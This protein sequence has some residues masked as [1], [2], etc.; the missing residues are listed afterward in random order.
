MSPLPTNKET[1]MLN[2]SEQGRK[3]AIEAM[4]S[5]IMEMSYLEE[6]LEHIGSQLFREEEEREYNELCEVKSVLC[7]AR[8][9]RGKLLKYELQYCMYDLGEAAVVTQGLIDGVTKR[10]SS[11]AS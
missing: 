3:V 1:E 6:A 9:W 8:E 10:N 7:S 2:E 4:I 11:T 5:Y